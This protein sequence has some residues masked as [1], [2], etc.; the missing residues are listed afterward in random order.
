M[1]PSYF[2]NFKKTLAFPVYTTGADRLPDSYFNLAEPEKSLWLLAPLAKEAGGLGLCTRTK[3]GQERRIPFSDTQ[4]DGYR[5]LLS[6]IKQTAAEL[7][8]IKRFNDPD[9]RPNE[10]WVREMKRYGFLPE[11][12]DVARDQVDVY[13]LEEE[14]WRSF[15]PVP[16]DGRALD[17]H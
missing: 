10:H 7:N 8:R 16:G 2:D 13:E 17:G 5:K 11:E 15:Y 1:P 6:T 14:Y 4:D 12:F 3:D 9:F